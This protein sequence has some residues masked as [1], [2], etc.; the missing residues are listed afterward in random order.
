MRTHHM[1]EDIPTISALGTSSKRCSC[2]ANYVSFPVDSLYR[3][4]KEN[5]YRR[6]PRL[7]LDIADVV[8]RTTEH[9]YHVGAT[10]RLRNP[11]TE[12]LILKKD[13]VVD[14]S[15]LRGETTL[16]RVKDLPPQ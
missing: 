11:M 8:I 13:S 9:F 12:A 15:P 10:E 6:N 16:P 2:S 1:R 7:P 3:P 14:D 5:K 4:E